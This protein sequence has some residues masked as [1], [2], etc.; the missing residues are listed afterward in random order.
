[1]LGL[2]THKRKA[3]DYRGPAPGSVGIVSE[4]DTCRFFLKYFYS[5]IQRTS[6]QQLYE[7]TWMMKEI[8]EK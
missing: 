5:S 3:R 2:E 7:Y 8:S 6:I 4:I 1:M